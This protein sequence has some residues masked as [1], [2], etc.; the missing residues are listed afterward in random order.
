MEK[1]CYV[2]NALLDFS[3]TCSYATLKKYGLEIDENCEYTERQ[4]GL[5]EEIQSLDDLVV[6]PGG[7][8]QNSAR[9]TQWLL[10][11]IMGDKVVSFIGCVGGDEF[12]ELLAD[13][14]QSIGVKTLY[15]IHETEP[16][17]ITAGLVTEDDKRTLCAKLGAAN[18]FN[19]RHLR[20]PEVENVLKNCRIL[21]VEGYF[22]SHSKTAVI[23]VAKHANSRGKTF[24]FNLS[25]QYI[26]ENHANDLKEIIPR[27]DILFGNEME[28]KTLAVQ[29]ESSLSDPKSIVKFLAN[30]DYFS[31]PKSGR[32]VI[33]TRGPDSVFVCKT[34]FS[35]LEF[36]VKKVEDIED[37]IGAG[38]AFVAGYLAS[39]IVGP[40]RIDDHINFA[41]EIART[42][43]VHRGCTF[44]EHPNKNLINLL[45]NFK[46]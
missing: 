13:K 45:K 4:S 42:I 2:G 11:P 30:T 29:I 39:L 1:I 41:I 17:G 27:V 16:T 33:M 14:L 37:T 32:T 44:P 8:A 40:K 43:I 31:L 26:C 6:T 5:I 35:A 28:M 12:G 19:L 25:A 24:A 36:S 9:V 38:D 22:L 15:H 34:N 21:Y 20:T 23:E 46:S 7:S 3:G 18:S 10:K